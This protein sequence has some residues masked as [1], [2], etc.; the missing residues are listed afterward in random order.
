MIK[1]CQCTVSIDSSNDIVNSKV[2]L[3][4]NLSLSLSLRDVHLSTV[5]LLHKGL[6]LGTVDPRHRPPVLGTQPGAVCTVVG[7]SGHPVAEVVHSRQGSEYIGAGCQNKGDSH[8][9]LQ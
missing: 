4:C 1:C 8:A 2:P 7:G 6:S 5:G 3:S 9:I